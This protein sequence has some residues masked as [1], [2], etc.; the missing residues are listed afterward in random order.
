VSFIPFIM[1]RSP[2]AKLIR[3]IDA[4]DRR[5]ERLAQ[6]KDVMK[7]NISALP[8]GYLEQAF[9]RAESVSPL[10]KTAGERDLLQS[11]QMMALHRIQR[12]H[13]ENRP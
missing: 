6:L 10:A 2:T 13:M 3:S 11:I 1:D 8:Y 4:K 5:L 12:I 7:H 9:R